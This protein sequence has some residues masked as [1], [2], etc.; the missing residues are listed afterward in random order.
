MRKNVPI[1]PCRLDAPRALFVQLSQSQLSSFCLEKTVPQKACLQK[2]A[3]ERSHK[4]PNNHFEA[5]A[6]FSRREPNKGALVNHIK[7]SV[8][9]RPIL[10]VGTDG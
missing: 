6:E 10:E 7:S 2:E 5:A 8:W 9:C 1:S 4:E 3:Y